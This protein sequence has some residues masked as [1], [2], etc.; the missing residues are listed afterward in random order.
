VIIGKTPANGQDKLELVFH[1]GYSKPLLEAYGTNVI[2]SATQD[3]ILIDGKRLINS[4]NLGTEQGYTVQTFIKYSIIKNGY[5]KAL[6]NLGYNNLNSSHESPGYSYGVRIQS[7]SIGLGTEIC[8]IGNKKFYPSVFALLRTNFIGGESYHAAGLDFFKVTPRFGYSGGLNLNYR[9]NKKT[10]IYAG[11]TY[12][13]DNT[14]DKHTDET[15]TN[16]V[17]TIVFRDKAN[18][19][20]GLQNDRR[21]AY[22]SFYIGMNFF[23]K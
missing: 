23:V 15:V 9:F 21:I 16:D 1:I 6:F 17:H 2:L 18:S 5:L 13:Y 14:W 8:P 11:W 7:F 19:T 4:N 3:Y 10:G 20:N 12:S 22:S